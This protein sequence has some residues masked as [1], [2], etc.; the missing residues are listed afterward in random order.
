MLRRPLLLLVGSIAASAVVAHVTE[1]GQAL[2]DRRTD[3]SLSSQLLSR[4]A[5]QSENGTASGAD[6]DDSDNLGDFS[7]HKVSVVLITSIQ[8]ICLFYAFQHGITGWEPLWVL[9]IEGTNYCL[10]ILQPGLGD[11][12]TYDGR[13]I[14][15]LRY[16]G[17]MV[18]CPV[19]LMFLT[20]MTTYGGR[21]APVRLVPLL[22]A[23][24]MM[25]LAGVTACAYGGVA[26]WVIYLLSCACGGI[27]I[28]LSIIC[29]LSLWE[30]ASLD[31]EFCWGRLRHA[32]QHEA[33]DASRG[34]GAAAG[35]LY[36]ARLEA[37]RKLIGNHMVVLR[38]ITR[39]DGPPVSQPNLVRMPGR[40]RDVDSALFEIAR[41]LIGRRCRAPAT[42]KQA[43]TW[44]ATAKFL[45][46][47]LQV[48]T[49]EVA[50]VPGHQQRK[51][52]MGPAAGAAMRAVLSEIADEKPIT[53]HLASL[54]RMVYYCGGERFWSQAC[55]LCM[56]TCFLIGWFIFPIA[57]TLGPPGIGAV[58]LDAE[59]RMY[60]VGDVLA[61]NCFAC[62]GVFVKHH[63]LRHL[64]PDRQAQTAAPTS[65]ESAVVGPP[66][67]PRMD[68]RPSQIIHDE[69]LSPPAL[70][71]S[72]VTAVTAPEVTSTIQVE[73]SQ[74]PPASPKSVSS[75]GCSSPSMN[76]MSSE[77]TEAL[78]Q[79]AINA[80]EP[81]CGRLCTANGLA[82]SLQRVQLDQARALCDAVLRLTDAAEE[83]KIMVEET[84]ATREAMGCS[85]PTPP[86]FTQQMSPSQLLV[87]KSGS[88]A[89][90]GWA[91]RCR[92]GQ[93]S[94]LS[95]SPTTS[96]PN[97]PCGSV[98]ASPPGSP[99]TEA[100]DGGDAV[101]SKGYR[102]MGNSPSS[103]CLGSQRP[104]EFE[105]TMPPTHALT[106]ARQQR[107]RRQQQVGTASMQR[108]ESAGRITT[109]KEKEQ[110]LAREKE[111]DKYSDDKETDK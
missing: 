23:N 57:W 80:L 3:V 6:D 43:T 63:Y 70:R 105:P 14:S 81:L 88:L 62:F 51:P 4:R 67:R 65:S 19:L 76:K 99:K 66:V 72:S 87:Q 30:L 21:P 46:A 102:M 42:P 53:G 89:A 54:E 69:N 31:R 110:E 58:S 79:H 13:S 71:R 107:L 11:L 59:E 84:V 68:R 8:L 48:S 45:A 73:L 17:W 100:I 52:D 90:K 96:A 38:D 39:P 32:L 41:R 104:K 50:R 20:A 109:M 36:T 25:I 5:L 78:L 27:V 15:W 40:E 29:L 28:T 91:P 12:E 83:E 98:T 49:A 37:A 10:S 16:A 18:T 64:N 77:T 86:L 24:Q 103:P 92:A 101:N 47:R 75:A 55:I 108:A 97:S 22:I 60:A 82:G 35:H 106:R 95:N 94:T 26:K 44:A 74:I 111:S 93:Y 2:R 7:A 61:K 34:D 56:T 33:P 9:G 1:A 85:S